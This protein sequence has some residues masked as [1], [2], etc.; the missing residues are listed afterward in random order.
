MRSGTLRVVVEC[1]KAERRGVG[2]QESG[3]PTSKMGGD[4]EA[5]KGPLLLPLV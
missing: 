4:S 2:I 5:E 1:R 3:T